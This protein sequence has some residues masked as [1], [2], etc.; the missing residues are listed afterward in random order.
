MFALASANPYGIWS[1]LDPHFRLVGFGFLQDRCVSSHYGSLIAF[2]L[3]NSYCASSG[4]YSIFLGSCLASLLQDGACVFHYAPGGRLLL[5]INIGLCLESTFNPAWA[6]GFGFAFSALPEAQQ[7]RL[8]LK[9]RL[10]VGW[11]SRTARTGAFPMKN[12]RQHA[13]SC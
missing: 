12:L 13:H 7:I 4:F 2:A 10:P 1:M 8:F 5:L 6:V 11:L 9:S 3:A